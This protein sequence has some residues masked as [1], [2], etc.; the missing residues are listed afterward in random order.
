MTSLQAPPRDVVEALCRAKGPKRNVLAYDEHIWI[1]YGS[2]VTLGEAAMQQYVHENADA[3]IVRVPR[4]LDAFST[5]SSRGRRMTC[6]V[7]EHVKGGDYITHIRQ[8]PEDA[9]RVLEAI[10]KAVRHIWDIPIPPDALPGPLER[11]EP[12][13]RFFSDSGAQRVFNDLVELE[14]WINDKVEEAGYPDRVRLQGEPLQICH[15]DLT[16]FNVKIGEPITILDWG[17]SGIYPRAFDEFAL[18]HQFNLEGLKFAKALHRLLFG[19]RLSK[20]MRPL[21]IAARFLQWGLRKGVTGA[22]TSRA[23]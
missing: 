15:C 3:R 5:T 20:A 2:G 18:F 9:G 10:A 16:Q 19:P 14:T 8:H 23:G 1:K 17:Y 4:V 12:E 6:I 21:S 7:M 11:E 13:D 22:S